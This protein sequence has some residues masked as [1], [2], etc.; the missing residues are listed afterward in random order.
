[1]DEPFQYVYVYIKSEYCVIGILY[2]FLFGY[3]ARLKKMCEL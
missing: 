2:Y 1:M 3:T